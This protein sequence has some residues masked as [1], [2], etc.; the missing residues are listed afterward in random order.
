MKNCYDRDG[1]TIDS[2]IIKDLI[3]SLVTKGSAKRNRCSMSTRETQ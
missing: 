2:Y 3:F 1:E